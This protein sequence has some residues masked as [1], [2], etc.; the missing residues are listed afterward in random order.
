MRKSENLAEE[1]ATIGLHASSGL[2]SCLWLQLCKLASTR[3]R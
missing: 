3:G 1:S 2:D